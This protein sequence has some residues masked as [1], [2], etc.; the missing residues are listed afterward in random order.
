MPAGGWTE[1]FDA[2]AVTTTALCR[3]VTHALTTL[4]V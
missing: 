1:T 4:L 2:A 3:R